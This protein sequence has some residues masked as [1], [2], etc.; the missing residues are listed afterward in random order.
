MIF[1]WNQ[2]SIFSKKSVFIPLGIGMRPMPTGQV[3]KLFNDIRQ[4]VVNMV[5]LQ[6]SLSHKQY[7]VDRLVYRKLT[8]N[9]GS[10]LKRAEDIRRSS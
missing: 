8:S 2:V 6:K 3:T 9:V 4:D 5:E 10:N 7:Q 1:W